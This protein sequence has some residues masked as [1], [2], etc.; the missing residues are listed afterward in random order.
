MEVNIRLWEKREIGGGRK[1][2]REREREMLQTV[3]SITDHVTEL[4]LFNGVCKLHYCG[5]CIIL[6][7]LICIVKLHVI[8]M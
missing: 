1:G 4:G 2:E 5:V 8:P 3:K 7:K 6:Y